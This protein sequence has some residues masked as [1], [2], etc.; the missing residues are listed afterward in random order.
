MQLKEQFIGVWKLKNLYIQNDNGVKFYP[1]GEDV[2]GLIMYNVDNY[3]NVII[4]QGNL[5][6]EQLPVDVF[7]KLS[8]EDKIFLNLNHIAYSGT[9][10]VDVQKKAVIHNVQVIPMKNATDIQFTRFYHFR[11]NELILTTL[12]M[13][14]NNTPQSNTPIL[15][16]KR[17][18]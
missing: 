6:L 18:S 10:K 7:N 1:L 2:N 13:E 15:V 17:W 11:E 5:P 9:F 3:M 8:D 16:W 12:P 4:T 14:L